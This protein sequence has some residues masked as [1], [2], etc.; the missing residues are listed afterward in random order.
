MSPPSPDATAG[1]GG[2]RKLFWVA[3]FG[4][5][6]L[7]VAALGTT[8]YLAQQELR[9]RLD[10]LQTELDAAERELSETR[11]RARVVETTLDRVHHLSGQLAESLAELH[12][13][14]APPPAAQD[15]PPDAGLSGGG[16]ESKA[17]ES[18]PSDAKTTGKR[19]AT[20]GKPESAGVEAALPG[21]AEPAPHVASD[22]PSAAGRSEPL[23]AVAEPPPDLPR[24]GAP[25]E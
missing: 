14:T 9:G 22:S 23:A 24:I 12:A 19:N 21:G 10:A 4:V 15:G 13:L 17:E 18:S 5:V 1:R 3:V 25:G 2:L 11:T 20:P 16:G 6:L 7:A 8:G